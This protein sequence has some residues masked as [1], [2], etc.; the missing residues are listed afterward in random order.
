MGVYAKY[1]TYI[2]AKRRMGEDDRRVMFKT[3]ERYLREYD[4]VLLIEEP[5]SILPKDILKDKPKRSHVSGQRILILSSV[6]W[7]DQTE[8]M[9]FCQISKEEA[10][11]FREI[12]YTYEFSDR[13]FLLPKGH[14][15]YASLHRLVDTGIL[16][17]EE[18]FDALLQ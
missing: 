5:G 17:L 4:K 15:N 18:F 8:D 13:F 11:H 6:S 2:K 3:L 9:T 10:R 14:M 12:Y 16:S 1:R 7:K